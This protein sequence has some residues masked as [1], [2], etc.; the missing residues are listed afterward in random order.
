MPTYEYRC[1]GCGNAFELFQQM[2]DEPLKKCPRCG[3]A[4]RRMIGTGAGVIFKGGRPDAGREPC[5]GTV[6]PC[7]AP[8]RCCQK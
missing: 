6:D 4:V 1:D 7:D 3:G 8:K 2:A 5:C